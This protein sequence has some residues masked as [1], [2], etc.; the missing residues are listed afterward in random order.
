MKTRLAFLSLI[1]LAASVPVFANDDAPETTCGEI[2][3]DKARLA[4]YDKSLATKN[5]QVTGHKDKAPQEFGLERQKE[6][7]Q[8]KISAHVKSI[9]K[10]PY[11][12]AKITL[13]N[14]QVWKQL[15]GGN[16][17]LKTGDEVTINRGALGSFNL[18]KAGYNR[19]FK[20]KRIK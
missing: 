12:L 3:D 9:K 6:Y 16:I 20:V 4:C 13:D 17:R 7:E 8:D 2:K 15:D 18:R 5:E 1:L 14:G 10:N 19:L 11:G